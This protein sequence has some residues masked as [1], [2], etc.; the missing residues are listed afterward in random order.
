MSAAGS[1][2]SWRLPGLAILLWAGWLAPA[3][4][5]E[6]VHDRLTALAQEIIHTTAASHPMFA[7]TLGIPGH[8]GELED[9]SEA[10]RA[11]ELGRLQKWR[12]RLRRIATSPGAKLSMVDADDARLLQAQLDRALNELQ[13]YQVDRKSY[14]AA[15]IEL[16]QA[17]YTQLHELPVA[18]R[19]G[20]TPQQV[21][22]AWRD[23]VDRLAKTPAFLAAAQRLVTKPGHLYGIVGSRQLAGAPDLF[24]G[25]LTDAAKNQFGEG[26][27]DF[28]RFV[29][30]RDAAL[31]AIA[32]TK[33]SIDARVAAWP[34]NF[35]M[36]RP[37][38]DR[39]LRDEKLLPFTAD[40]LV[41]M[42]QM[43]LEHGWAEEAWLGS[44]SGFEH[45]PFGPRSG[46]GLAP[47]GAELLGY[48]RDRIAELRRFLA[49]RQLITIPDW[50]GELKIEETPSFLR[51]VSPGASMNSPRLFSTSTTGYYY[52]TPPDSLQEAAARLDMNEDFDRDRIL[53]TAAHEA[54]P[55]HFLQLSIAKRHSDFVRKIQN[56]SEFAEGWAFY[57]EEMFVRVG[58]Y[59]Q[60]LDARL[61][62]ARWERVRGA[63]AIVDPMLATGQWDFKRA[64][65]FYSE[66]TGFTPE[67][68]EAAVAGIA[69]AP[70]YFIAYTAG[71]AQL[72]DLL[73]QYLNKAGERASLRDFHD[74][75][76]SYGT[77]PFAI[78]APELL[79]DLDKSADEVRAAANY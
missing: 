56:S 78:V 14:P 70:G 32:K 19:D 68:S 41:R 77:T 57:G 65:Q 71:R 20:A 53:S 22:A 43:E 61:F 7:T 38:Y 23:I 3:K 51:P 1:C 16:I 52:I 47:G 59:G 69:S 29:G 76:L 15:G 35:A 11:A 42:G 24:N 36:G 58:L 12:E 73:G 64:V 50:L 55:G 6:T 33:A 8:D 10:S 62:T 79:A 60:D 25:A 30:A 75:L 74:R 44:L 17:I 54:I 63:R 9:R 26:S 21:S 46:G 40:D 48:Y 49:D 28:R 2:S 66:Q 5:D 45:V 67:A 37:A 34:E 72:E 31:A 18:G 39:M 27:D 13:V 4:A